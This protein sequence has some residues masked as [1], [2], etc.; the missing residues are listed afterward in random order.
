[1]HEDQ[2]WFH[3]RTN[4]QE[5]EYRLKSAGARNGLFL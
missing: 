5:A 2:L 1:L 3:P 4:R